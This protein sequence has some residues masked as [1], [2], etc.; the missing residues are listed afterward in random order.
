MWKSLNAIALNILALIAIY[1]IK[2][3]LFIDKK[4]TCNLGQS[5]FDLFTDHIYA[6]IVITFAM[7]SDLL[8]YQDDTVRKLARC[9]LEQLLY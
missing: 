6:K 2:K 1:K 4:Y 5:N 7:N 9:S 3:K 8:R